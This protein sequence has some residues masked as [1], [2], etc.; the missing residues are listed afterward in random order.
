MATTEEWQWKYPDVESSQ[1]YHST[2]VIMFTSGTTGE[3]K[4]V[5][6]SHCNYIAAAVS[7]AHRV[8]LHPEWA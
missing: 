8:S 2:I 4:G 6:I 7:Y 5:E 3:A 1:D